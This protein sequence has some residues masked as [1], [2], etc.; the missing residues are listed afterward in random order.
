[1]NSEVRKLID[2]LKAL[3]KD[4]KENCPA[5]ILRLFKYQIVPSNQGGKMDQAFST[6]VFAEGDARQMSAYQMF[7][8]CRVIDHDDFTCDQMKTLFR[9]S[10]PLSSEFIQT[11]GLEQSWIYVQRMLKVFDLIDD[12]ADLKELFFAFNGYFAAYHNW[13]QFWFPFAAGEVYRMIHKEDVEA[14]AKMFNL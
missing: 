13:V 9:E 8:L 6:M 4:V 14:M 5:E 10:V 3:E 7:M 1:M 12:K 11:C 2:D